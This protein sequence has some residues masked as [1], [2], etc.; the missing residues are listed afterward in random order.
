MLIRFSRCTVKCV[1]R[2]VRN[3]GFLYQQPFHAGQCISNNKLFVD[4]KPYLFLAVLYAFNEF[5]E[6]N[7]R[8]H[9]LLGRW[10]SALPACVPDRRSDPCGLRDAFSRTAEDPNCWKRRPSLE[11]STRTIETRDHSLK[12]QLIVHEILVG[13]Y[14]A[15]STPG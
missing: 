4:S 2:K 1:S 13:E 6:E 14:H 15:S 8:S 10:I 12:K 11:T 5:L 3:S 9:S 7:V